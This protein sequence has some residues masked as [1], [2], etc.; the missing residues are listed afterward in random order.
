MH[1]D[2]EFESTRTMPLSSFDADAGNGPPRRRVRIALLAALAAVAVLAGVVA[3]IA[4]PG[5]RGPAG[6]TPPAASTTPL[7]PAFDL[8]AAR[9]AEDVW[10]DAVVRLPHRLPDGRGFAAKARLDDDRFVGVPTRGNAYEPPVVY[11]VSSRE[12]DELFTER[13]DDAVYSQP[14]VSVS[15]RV[16]V[17]AVKHWP[18][19]GDAAQARPEVWVAPRSGGPARRRAVFDSGTEV[20]PFGADAGVFAAVTSRQNSTTV[21]RL[22]SGG[23][24]EEVAKAEGEP[25]PLHGRWLMTGRNPF[26]FV[27]VVTGE[28]RTTKM[29]DGLTG[30]TCSPDT[31]IGFDGA[32]LVAHRFDGTNPARIRGLVKR[33]VH[34]F[35]PVLIEAGRFI[36]LQSGGKEYLWD[37][38]KGVVVVMTAAGSGVGQLQEC[39]FSDD[40]QFLL[41][42]NRV[43]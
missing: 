39:R 12:V 15:E 16:I 18:V 3:I 29:L 8:A 10:P 6:P 36:R 21:Y 23:S 24:P 17:V 28:S 38:D 43:A 35:P 2:D 7:P 5:G 13:P 42:L 34:N 40:E 30:V 20:S 37:H 32:D 4:W 25:D 22:P 11:D 19:I 31:C 14:V 9:P 1:S 33:D 41:D 26:T 27:D